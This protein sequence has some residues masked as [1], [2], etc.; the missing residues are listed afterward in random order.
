MAE[1]TCFDILDPPFFL[2]QPLTSSLPSGLSPPRSP[3]DPPRR[4]PRRPPWLLAAGVWATALSVRP[5]ALATDMRHEPNPMS[6]KTDP[7]PS[8]FK[9]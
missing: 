7:K 4:R 5:R 6:S 8:K 1:S 9:G 2:L 3:R